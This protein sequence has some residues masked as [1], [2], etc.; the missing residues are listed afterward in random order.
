MCVSKIFVVNN[1]IS[2]FIKV[3][4]SPGEILTGPIVSMDINFKN[5]GKQDYFIE[6]CMG[7]THYWATELVVLGSSY[8]DCTAT[9][10]K[11]IEGSSWQGMVGAFR[12]GAGTSVVKQHYLSQYP[13]HTYHFQYPPAPSCDFTFAKAGSYTVSYRF[14]FFWHDKQLCRNNED[15]CNAMQANMHAGGYSAEIKSEFEI[16]IETVAYGYSYISYALTSIA[17]IG[18]AYKVYHCFAYHE[19]K[20]VELMA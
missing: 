13:F 14:S 2:F 3:S 8:I 17:L 16:P 5:T 12:L 6:P 4:A 19:A 20:G 7:I 9:I 10:Y 18:I 1:N 15:T 11:C